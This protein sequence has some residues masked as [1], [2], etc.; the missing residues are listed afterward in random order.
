MIFS[1]LKNT[2]INRLISNEKSSFDTA[3]ASASSEALDDQALIGLLAD[4]AGD[5]K[6]EK[7]VP[8]K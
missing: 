3:A 6:V 8:P 4:V 2:L 1:R 5:A 7:K